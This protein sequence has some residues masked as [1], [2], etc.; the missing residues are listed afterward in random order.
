MGTLSLERIAE[1]KR[2]GYGFTLHEGCAPHPRFR[3]Y[4]VSDKVMKSAKRRPEQV[5]IN[6]NR[7]IAIEIMKDRMRRELE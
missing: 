6:R 7:R 5:R 4:H 2:V 3:N 1:A